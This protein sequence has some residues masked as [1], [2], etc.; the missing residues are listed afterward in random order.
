MADPITDPSIGAAIDGEDQ[1]EQSK[2][3]KFFTDPK[4]LATMLVM[5]AALAQ[6]RRGQS[7]GAHLGKAAV[8]GLGFRGGLETE[9]DAQKARKAEAGSVQ[10]DRLA[11][12][13]SDKERNRVFAE[14]NDITRL[15]EAYDVQQ[16][17]LDR[18][19]ALAIARMQAN[20]MT[21]GRKES[22]LNT[23]MKS[24]SDAYMAALS[25]PLNQGKPVDPNQYFGMPFFVASLLDPE[26][27]P[28]GVFAGF[29]ATAP[30]AAETTLA[31]DGTPTEQIIPTPDTSGAAT[32]AEGRDRGFAGGLA[33]LFGGTSS[34]HRP[35]TREQPSTIRERNMARVVSGLELSDSEADAYLTDVRGKASD[36]ARLALM[37]NKEVR[38][39]FQ[40]SLKS[41]L[42]FN[43]TE[44]KNLQEAIGNLRGP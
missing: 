25:D 33:D 7:F 10:E 15:S 42:L 2:A 9:L 26:A 22:L 6:N 3:G 16:G 44:L 37:D 5:G 41:R 34:R 32:V 35:T 4:N 19:N 14:Q 38:A 39:L 43:A 24:A 40:L 17:Q 11:D 12:Q 27:L 20:A 30:P 28:E 18:D 31:P 36:P 21:A 29:E 1:K 13:A 23:L 8:G